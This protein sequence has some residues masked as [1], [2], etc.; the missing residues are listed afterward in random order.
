M[1]DQYVH[2]VSVAGVVVNEAG[3]VL[4]VQRQDNSHWEPPGGVLERDET[5][6]AG[7]AR[8]VHEET[9]IQVHVD[10]LTGVYKNMRLGVVALV[11]RCHPLT[12]HARSTTE[13]HVARWV[14]AQEIPH[15]MTPAYA[16]RV[17]DALRGGIAS[18]SHD[19][20]N[21]IR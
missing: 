2:S 13:A 20:H 16:I 9:G 3:D 19:G 6:E 21:L 14:K 8:E 15:L 10:Q 5:F 11:Y 1:P 17:T 12:G 18:R 7:V 4:V